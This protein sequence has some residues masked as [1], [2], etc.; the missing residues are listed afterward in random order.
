MVSNVYQHNFT[1]SHPLGEF[2]LAHT[3]GAV[4][5]LIYWEGINS[6]L[7]TPIELE[8]Q[9]NQLLSLLHA[10]PDD[11]CFEFH[12][13]R[14]Y[15]SAP[16]DAYLNLNHQIIRNHEFAHFVRQENAQHLHQYAM[17]NTVGLVIT[18]KP[19]FSLLPSAKGQLKRQA[20]AAQRLSNNIQGFL[21][22][23]PGATVADV[24]EYCARIYQTTHRQ[25]FSSGHEF[26]YDPRYL[27]NE[28]LIAEK[29]QLI[30][31]HLVQSGSVI[32]TL[33]LYLYPDAFPAWTKTITQQPC[34]LHISA[35][36]QPIDTKRAM[37]KSESDADLSEGLMSRRGRDYDEKGL[38][39]MSGFRAFVADNGLQIF[40]NAFIINLY[41]PPEHSEQISHE[42]VD[43]IGSNG[44]QV[45]HADYLQYPY[46][47]FSQPGQG[48]LNSLMRP[49]H[50]KQVA[51]MLPVQV[52]DTGDDSPESMRLGA[53]RQVVN[54]DFTRKEVAHAFTAAMTRGG[55]G[56]D[57]VT[58]IAELY[59]M[60]SDFSI[61]EVGSSY[62]WLVE[63]FGGSYTKI[64]PGEMAINPLPPYAVS[65]PEKELPL[66]VAIASGTVNSL[67]FLL[68]DGKTELDVHQDA[69]SQLA[70]QFCY[71]VPDK[72]CD[73]PTLEHYLNALRVAK[74]Y[75]DRPEQLRAAADMSAKLDSFLSTQAGRL[76]L[77]KDTLA[78]S[79][80]I[81]GVDLKDVEKASPK[82]LQFYL[83]F[84]SLKLTFNAFA[85]RNRAFI[86]LD[87]L[88]KFVK[89]KPEIVGKLV[90]EIVRM[91]AKENTFLWLISQGI[92]EVE[93]IERS[94]IENMP[95]RNL[96]YRTGG[97]DDIAERIGM[98][99]GPRTTWEG[100]EYPVGKPFRPAIRSIG[101]DYYNL[102]LTFPKSLL[103]L[104]DTSPAALTLKDKIGRDTKDPIER[105][106]VFARL[107]EAHQ[108]A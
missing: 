2:C 36:V 79:D 87:E 103:D 48:Y 60:G 51:N 58:T 35:I 5:C 78:L 47:R 37:T 82:L 75:N 1:W 77:E 34:P 99:E 13:W 46:Y 70:L 76:F 90:S 25:A 89:S 73:T 108:H 97:H 32:K 29:P 62:R 53:A 20:R 17:T 68:T 100:F 102:H 71:A 67:A 101:D 54:F 41:G 86:V 88:H 21:R 95:M 18:S 11:Y 84:I 52:Y 15:D 93:A 107:M 6:D 28:Q 19:K 4:S 9:F 55:K 96:L 44:G 59:P 80:G 27:L 83:V 50:S 69:A 105:L 7:L 91:G 23:L 63:S 14:E 24:G 12:L 40:K 65:D 64:D 61:I 49:D 94:V 56:V 104:A 26:H 33:F 85:S 57:A 98:P 42:L 3:D 92:E 38:N 72:A 22:H 74:D 16:V 81:V 106:Q 30:D 43:W 66:N 31:D 45:R 39:D 8:S 10:L